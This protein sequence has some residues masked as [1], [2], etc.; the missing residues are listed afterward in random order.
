MQR[1]SKINP[2]KVFF[3]DFTACNTY[4]NGEQAAAKVQCPTL[5][6]LAKNDMMTPPKASASISKLIEN[7]KV[8]IIENCGHAIMSEQP[9]ALLSALFSFAKG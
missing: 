3:T 7:S 1:I 2:E 5:F 8:N 9:D 4:S 6:I